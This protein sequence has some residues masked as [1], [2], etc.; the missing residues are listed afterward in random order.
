MGL[1]DPCS[2]AYL[3]RPFQDALTRRDQ[4]SNHR[5][6]QRARVAQ[7]RE[8]GGNIP[9]GQAMAVPTNANERLLNEREAADFLNVSVLTLR[10]W[11]WAG[12]PPAFVKLGSAVRYA[13][14]DLR[15]FLAA[16]R[17]VPADAEADGL[18]HA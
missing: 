11:R 8:T 5:P 2:D 3:N 9:K 4:G 14:D 18:R 12:K 17:R 1:T 7:L 10:R 16:G 13:P 6:S 15:A